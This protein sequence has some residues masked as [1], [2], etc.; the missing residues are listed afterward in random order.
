MDEC[1]SATP[2]FTDEETKLGNKNASGKKLGQHKGNYLK[3]CG[4]CIYCSYYA[5]YQP[6]LVTTSYNYIF[7]ALRRQISPLA[8][9]QVPSK[10]A[11][12]DY[13]PTINTIPP[14]PQVSSNGNVMRP[15]VKLIERNSAP[16]SRRGSG[17]SL[18]GGR[19]PVGNIFT[20]NPNHTK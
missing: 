1:S 18:V 14:T 4:F 7:L 11:T 16:S 17:E 12:V 15:V 10:S 2:E 19:R 3:E 9:Y 6:Q 20:L 5:I 13:L 8:L